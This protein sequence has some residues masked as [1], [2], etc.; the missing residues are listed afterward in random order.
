ME[1]ST[2]TTNQQSVMSEQKHTPGP[3][4]VNDLGYVGTAESESGWTLISV[5]AA[6]IEAD[7]H[8]I[9]LPPDEEQKA[10]ARL[11]AAAP[12]L[13]STLQAASAQLDS[14]CRDFA[15]LV[16]TSEACMSTNALRARQGSLLAKLAAVNCERAAQKAQAVISKATGT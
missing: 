1:R 12:E 11:I 13:L 8:F 3:W 16:E 4:K 15:A 9:K 10:N 6:E 14:A 7:G 5:P 2:I